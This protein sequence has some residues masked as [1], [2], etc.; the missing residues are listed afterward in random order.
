ML[1]KVLLTFLAFSLLKLSTEAEEIQSYILKYN[2]VY[3]IDLI[4]NQ[5]AATECLLLLERHVTI[6]YLRLIHTCSTAVL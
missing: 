2:F 1:E 3:S 4:D 6:C 5:A